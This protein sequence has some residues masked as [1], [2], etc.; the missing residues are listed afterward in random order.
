MQE[1]DLK[2]NATPIFHKIFQQ[3]RNRKKYLQNEKGHLQV[4]LY[5]MVKNLILSPHDLGTMKEYS[6]GCS[7]LPLLLNTIMEAITNEI[8]II[9]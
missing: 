2:K 4:I 9:I 1:N 6:Q 8:F 7:C 5:L 3:T